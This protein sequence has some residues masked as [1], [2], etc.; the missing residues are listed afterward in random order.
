MLG[1][2]TAVTFLIVGTGQWKCE[3]CWEREYCKNKGSQ[4]DLMHLSI[5]Q[6]YFVGNTMHLVEAG[7][8][9]WD[10]KTC[11]AFVFP[12]AVGI[13]NISQKQNTSEKSKC[14]S[15]KKNDQCATIHDRMS[16]MNKERPR[17]RIVRRICLCV[18]FGIHVKG[19]PLSH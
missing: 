14:K 6:D 10:L 9:C 16:Q 4:K 2:I 12:R 15:I 3:H 7:Y 1:V 8:A 17:P 11:V 19:V 18:T 5:D 13:V